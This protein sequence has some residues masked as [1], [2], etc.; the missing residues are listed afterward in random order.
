MDIQE[1]KRVKSL[2]LYKRCLHYFLPYRMH[3]AFAT[4]AMLIVAGI[5]GGIAYMVKPIINHVFVHKD[6]SYLLLFALGL[7]ALEFV[8]VAFRTIQ[9]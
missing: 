6:A 4:L 5:Q 9:N 8:K 7:P 2:A 3:I 1:P